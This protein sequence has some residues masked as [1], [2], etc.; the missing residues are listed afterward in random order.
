MEE[1]LFQITTSLDH[2]L[3]QK[4]DLQNLL[5]Q[6]GEEGSILICFMP[7]ALEETCTSSNFVG[8]D[9]VM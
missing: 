2:I 8:D 3:S 6:Q 7:T 5:T 1:S 9:I 4:N